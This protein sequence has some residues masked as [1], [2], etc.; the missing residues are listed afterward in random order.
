MN[1]NKFFFIYLTQN[2]NKIFKYILHTS[3]KIAI[4]MLITFQNEIIILNF[5]L[6]K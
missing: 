5:N 1:Y 3:E 4:Y 6:R 2:L